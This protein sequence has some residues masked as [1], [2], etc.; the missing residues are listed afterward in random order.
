ME[1][2]VTQMAQIL[3]TLLEA[4]FALACLARIEG[5]WDL[6]QARPGAANQDLQQDLEADRMQLYPLH[7]LAPEQKKAT[8]WVGA[9]ANTREE[10]G[11]NGCATSRDKLARNA[12]QPDVAAPR[13]VAACNDEISVLCRSQQGGDNLWW[14]LKIAVKNADEGSLCLAY[15]LDYRGRKAAWSLLYGPVQK[16]D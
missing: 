14:M 2:Q 9:V 6:N 5:V 8:H 12:V 4:G 16:K 3:D 1:P 7:H 15:A 11:G 13:D 10:R